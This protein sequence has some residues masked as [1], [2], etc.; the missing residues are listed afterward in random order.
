M[1]TVQGTVQAGVMCPLVAGDNG[2]VYAID[3]L[4]QDL[5]PGDRVLLEVA[6]EPPDFGAMCDQGQAVDWR[7]VTRLGA[8]DQPARTWSKQ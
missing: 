7:R 4:P 5:Q 6:P 3:D 1:E 2:E 8:N